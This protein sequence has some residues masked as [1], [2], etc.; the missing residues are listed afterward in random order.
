MPDPTRLLTLDDLARRWGV[1][2]RT[3]QRMHKRGDL[4]AVRV[5]SQIRFSPTD[6]AV[7]ERAGGVDRVARSHF[8]DL[9]GKFG[10]AIATE[11]VMEDLSE[12]EARRRFDQ[13][14]ADRLETL[15]INLG[16]NVRIARGVLVR[17]LNKQDGSDKSLQR[18]DRRRLNRGV[19]HQMAQLGR[20]PARKPRSAPGRSD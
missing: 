18:A 20:R 6:I 3:L 13:R 16:G 15:R 5:G 2:V 17:E 1:S 4:P 10:L 8:R 12:D 19:S 7:F 9:I 11:A 14:Y